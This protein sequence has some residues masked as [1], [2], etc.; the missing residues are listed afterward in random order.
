MS[1]LVYSPFR[2]LNELH[3]DLGG[4]FDNQSSGQETSSYEAGNWTPHVDIKEDKDGF[5]VFADI[6]GVDPKDVEITLD[7]NILTI[8]GQ[9]SSESESKEE[10][11]KRRER[12]TGTFVRQFTLPDS[13]N[14]EEISAKANQGVL[15]LTIP[16]G[17]KHKPLTISVRS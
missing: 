13:A 17:E 14:G 4:I 5:K 7:R 16:K 11:Y 6:P 15:E 10:G 2:A 3:R 8:R 9:R 1:Q 12:V